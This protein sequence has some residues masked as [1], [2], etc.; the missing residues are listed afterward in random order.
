[1]K[2][3]LI[4]LIIAT[5]LSALSACSSV[6]KTT[7]TGKTE[8]KP[9]ENKTADTRTDPNKTTPTSSTV[10]ST[11]AKSDIAGNYSVTGA[12]LDGKDYRGELTVTKRDDVFQLSWNLGDSKYD[13]VGVQTGN[14]LAAAYTTGTDGK[15]CGAVVY[16][17]NA[18]DSIEGKWGEWGINQAG[19]EKAVP[20]EKMTNST[21]AFDVAGTN[22]DGTTYKGK[23][24]ITRNSEDVYQFSWDVG[25]KYMGTGV[26]MGEYLAAGSGS[27]Q[28]GFVIYEVQNGNLEGKW[29]VPGTTKLGTEKATKK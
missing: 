5:F 17:I 7:E 2:H 27:K 25:T 3:L 8:N 6:T 29:G 21:G 9:V 14:T 24:N 15:G 19:K 1:M 23:L 10:E 28:C 16:K 12:T 4:A 26:K 22:G 20:S 18:D 13:G 11:A